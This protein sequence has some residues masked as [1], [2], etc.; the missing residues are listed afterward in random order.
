MQLYEDVS[1]EEGWRQIRA[2][3]KNAKVTWGKVWH[4]EDMLGSL[5]SSPL[6]DTLRR[7]LPAGGRQDA[8]KAC[9]ACL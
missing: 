3:Y 2:A 7:Q 4:L 9:S 5:P 8:G 6:V 1:E